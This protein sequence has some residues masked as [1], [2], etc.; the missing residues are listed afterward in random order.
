MSHINRVSECDY[1]ESAIWDSVPRQIPND[2]W[3]IMDDGDRL[4][5]I[6][7]H[8]KNNAMSTKPENFKWIPYDWTGTNNFDYYKCSACGHIVRNKSKYC[9]DCGAKMEV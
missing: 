1:D 2:E 8:R 9:P 7:A 6:M 5:Y 3:N 4:A